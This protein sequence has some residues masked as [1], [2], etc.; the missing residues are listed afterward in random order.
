MGIKGHNEKYINVKRICL[1]RREKKRKER[2]NDVRNK[3]VEL[4]PKAL[5][6]S[7]IFFLFI[8]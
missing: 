6:V 1:G 4:K 2:G 7:M 8:K 5:S 3:D